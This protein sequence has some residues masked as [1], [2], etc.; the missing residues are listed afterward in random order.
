[1]DD[2]LLESSWVYQELVAEGRRR[3]FKIGYAQGIEI[4]RAQSIRQSIQTVV[5]TRFP[6]LA[7]LATKRIEHVQ[8][9]DMLQQ[10]HI[11][12]IA[13][14]TERKARRYLFALNV[15]TSSV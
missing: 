14:P 9:L 8:N 1:M 6:A 3:G 5:Q 4:G 12:M 7:D 2:D 13:A 11:A 10:I 15:Q